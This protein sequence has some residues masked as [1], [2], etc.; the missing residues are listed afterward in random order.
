M[1][2]LRIF[3]AVTLIAGLA[4]PVLGSGQEKAKPQEKMTGQEK[5]MTPEM[6]QMMESM[7]KY[8]MPG[9]EHE[10]LKKYAGDWDIEMKSWEKPGKHTEMV[11]VTRW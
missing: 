2:F 5:A 1:R 6:K 4:A 3:V 11:P 8:G 7:Q 9:K 10:Y